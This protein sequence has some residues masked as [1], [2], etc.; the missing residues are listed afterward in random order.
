MGPQEYPV[1]TGRVHINSGLDAYAP[2]DFEPGYLNESV[3]LPLANSET[4]C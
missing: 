1:S 2:L 3:G 4:M